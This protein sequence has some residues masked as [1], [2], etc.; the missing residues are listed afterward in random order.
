MN[1]GM[2]WIASTWMR[3]DVYNDFLIGN[4]TANTNIK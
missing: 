2:K 3:K 1:A 4:A